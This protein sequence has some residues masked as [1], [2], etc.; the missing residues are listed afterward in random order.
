MNKEHCYRPQTK[1]QE[2]Y[3]FT[4]TPVCDSV[5]V[6]GGELSIQG[7]LCPGG[8]RDP[9]PLSMVEEQAVRI[10]LECFLINSIASSL[11]SCNALYTPFANFVG[12][13]YY[14]NLP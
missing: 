12:R 8:D 5:H 1:L 6:G 13:T 4:L 10:L 9:L 3:V 11:A 7:G 2:G 14:G